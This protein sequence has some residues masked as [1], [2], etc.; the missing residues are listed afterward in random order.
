MARFDYSIHHVPGKLLYT[1]DAL[2]R[3]STSSATT[4]LEEEVEDYVDAVVTTLPAT[5]QRLHE[6]RDAQKQDEVCSLVMQ[7]CQSEWPRKQSVP[8]LLLPYWKVRGFL[9]VHNHLLLYN[10]RIVVPKLLQ[11]Q[12]MLRIHEGHQGIERCRMRAKTSV[13]WPG[14]CL[15]F[16]LRDRE[17]ICTN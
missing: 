2:S 7:Y 13:W 1:A 8:L 16:A 10:N 15:T 3:A 4:E 6:Y 9:T 12:T 17:A 11:R 14:L 5:E